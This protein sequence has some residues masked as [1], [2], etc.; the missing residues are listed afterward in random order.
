MNDTPHGFDLDGFAPYLSAVVAE[1]LSES[2]AREYRD[3]F[4]ISIPDWRVL[5]H[6]NHAD[7]A[8]VRDIEKR[9][10][11]EKSKVSR[12]VTRMTD[13]G[14]VQKVTHAGDKR[15]LHLSLTPAGRD[16]MAQILPMAQAF[17]REIE[18]RLGADYA[19]FARCLTK[20]R[21]GFDGPS[22]A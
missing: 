20:L 17:Q 22:G 16:L 21:G 4:G 6:L 8:S 3:R 12:A 5:V 14:L 11:M 1:H 10:V 13:R 19:V 7:G 18:A 15:L 2:L 9:V